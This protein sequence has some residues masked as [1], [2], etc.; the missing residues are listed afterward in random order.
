MKEFITDSIYFKKNK[1]DFLFFANDIFKWRVENDEDSF[2]INNE[3]NPIVKDIQKISGVVSPSNY[4]LINDILFLDKN[5]IFYYP[6]K[7]KN[8]FSKKYQFKINPKEI[9]IE[10]EKYMKRGY[11]SYLSY[12]SLKNIG[13]KRIEQFLVLLSSISFEKDFKYDNFKIKNNSTVFNI[14]KDK[15]ITQVKEEYLDLNRFIYTVHNELG[16]EY[17]DIFSHILKLYAELKCSD[18]FDIKGI[19]FF[20]DDNPIYDIFKKIS[21]IEISYIKEIIDIENSV[22]KKKSRLQIKKTDIKSSI[23]IDYYFLQKESY[24]SNK[25]LSSKDNYPTL[26]DTVKYLK[27]IF[28]FKDILLTIQLL[29]RMKKI[30]IFDMKITINPSLKKRLELRVNKDWVDLKK[31]QE[32]YSNV[33]YIYNDIID[34]IYTDKIHFSC[35]LCDNNVYSITPQQLFCSQ[36]G[37]NFALYRTNLKSVGVNKISL[38]NMIDGLENKTILLEKDKGGQLPVFLKQNK[39]FF[40]FWIDDK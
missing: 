6:E 24:F 9:Y 7:V 2:Y 14:V 30:K 26:I 17:V 29:E 20:E 12:S 38:E 40:S 19:V 18:P 25:V 33:D 39:D 27:N 8:E 15:K 16:Y 37:C 21:N 28:P 35:P 13:L 3:N 31:W 23:L 32:I 22:T 5:A 34:P 10:F 11:I 1:K 36:V 4:R